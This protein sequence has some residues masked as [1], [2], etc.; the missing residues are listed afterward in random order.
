MKITSAYSICSCVTCIS[1]YAAVVLYVRHTLQTRVADC[2]YEKYSLCHPAPDG[3][4]PVVLSV[5]CF[6]IVNVM[7]FVF[8]KSVIS[9]TVSLWIPSGSNTFCRYCTVCLH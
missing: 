9:E 8:F 6:I 4:F 5:Y 7:C 1:V 2:A 3:G